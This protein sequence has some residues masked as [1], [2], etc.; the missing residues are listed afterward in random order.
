MPFGDEQF[1]HRQEFGPGGFRAT[2]VKSLDMLLLEVVISQSQL[3]KVE[4]LQ[5]SRQGAMEY[6]GKGLPATHGREASKATTST[7]TKLREVMEMISADTY[8]REGHEQNKV[9]AMM[10]PAKS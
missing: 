9:L 6:P 10:P 2:A 5:R 3:H 8:T 7:R 4:T 1:G